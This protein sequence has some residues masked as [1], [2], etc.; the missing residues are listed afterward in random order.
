[1]RKIIVVSPLLALFVF[2]AFAVDVTCQAGEYLKDGNSTCSVCEPGYYC[3]GGTYT[4]DPGLGNQGIT[5]CSQTY[6][7][8]PAGASS[9]SQCS[10]TID[11]APGY[12]LP[13]GAVACA[14]CTADSFCPGLYDATYSSKDAQGITTCKSGAGANYQY[15][16]AGVSAQSFCYGTT[17]TDQCSKIYSVPG[18]TV[19]W[20]SPATAT[21]RIYLDN[22]GESDT[23]QPTTIGACTIQ[24]ASCGT[25]YSTNAS[26]PLFN[27]ILQSRNLDF[28][29]SAVLG[30]DNNAGDHFSGSTSGMTAGTFRLQYKDGTKIFGR[31]SCNSTNASE[32]GVQ[33]YATFTSSSS[34]VNCWCNMTGYQLNGQS[35]VTVNDS[36]WVYVHTFDVAN[37]CSYTCAN[38]CSRVLLL[39]DEETYENAL[40]GSYA[41]PCTPNT[42]NITWKDGATTLST[43][44]CSYGTEFSVP[45]APEVTG[46]KFLGY[47]IPSGN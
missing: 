5:Q 46:Y 38:G 30:L 8:S 3:V 36:K 9:S 18:A 1:M 23:T 20:A 34:G 25:G 32:F 6:R 39:S 28:D 2:D 22:E 15:S 29:E 10:D 7:F 26:Y 31:A 27:Y 44:Q 12:Y 13:A 19:T 41:T 43:N 47:R 42:Y 21:V 35:A 4:I 45:E 37:K 33:P 24:S 11:C 14:L 40:F 16:D 17:T